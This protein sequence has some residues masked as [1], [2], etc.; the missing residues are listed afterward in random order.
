MTITIFSQLPGIARLNAEIAARIHF[1]SNA[2]WS[3]HVLKRQ[4]PPAFHPTDNVFLGSI[5]PV[6]REYE[7][8]RQVTERSMSQCSSVKYPKTWKIARVISAEA[9]VQAQ[10]L[11]AYTAVVSVVHGRKEWTSMPWSEVQSTYRLLIDLLANWQNRQQWQ[12]IMPE[13]TMV[14]LKVAIDRSGCFIFTLELNAIG[15]KIPKM[16]IYSPIKKSAAHRASHESAEVILSKRL[17]SGDDTSS[18]LFLLVFPMLLRR[19]LANRLHDASWMTW[20][21]ILEAPD[22]LWILVH[23]LFDKAAIAKQPQEDV[24]LEK[25]LRELQRRK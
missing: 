3:R 4:I 12:L 9:L 1:R 14:H 2:L 17:D 16:T 24:N 10:E 11:K 13:E 23:P 8:A 21:F 15:R 7:I 5:D 22:V 6:T 25:I 19:R 20:H 18:H